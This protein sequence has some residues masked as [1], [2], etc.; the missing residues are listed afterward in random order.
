MVKRQPSGHAL[1]AATSFLALFSIV[2]LALYGL[3]LY[4]DFMV[5]DFGWSRTQVTSG[6]ALSKLVVGPLF[7]FVAGWVVDR[8]GPRRL[9]IAGVLMAGAALVGLGRMTALWMFYFFYLFNALGYVCGGPLPNQVL[10]ARWF[11]A[12]R[13]RAMGFA[14]LGIGIGGALVPLLSARLVAAYGWRGALQALG[15]I[16]IALALPFAWFV[17]E[18]PTSAFVSTSA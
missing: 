17:K 4:Y 6:N 1:V 2:G 8:F 9:M 5:R 18:S 11:D 10:L 14:Y 15:M 16:I 12:A 3:P 7:G 13:G